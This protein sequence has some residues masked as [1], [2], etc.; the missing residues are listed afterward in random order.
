MVEESVSLAVGLQQPAHHARRNQGRRSSWR[1]DCR[2]AMTR[3]PSICSLREFVR[4]AREAATHAWFVTSVRTRRAVEKM[5][6]TAGPNP[7]WAKG[8]AGGWQLG[9]ACKLAARAAVGN[10]PRGGKVHPGPEMK[11]S[12]HVALLSFFFLFFC[13]LSSSLLGLNLNL[14][15]VSNLVQICYQIIL[16]NEKYKL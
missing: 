12:A 6:L 1:M 11:Q 14:N 7:Q 16:W 3:R 8:H 5:D 2:R 9:P 13:F 15:L 4:V 10:G